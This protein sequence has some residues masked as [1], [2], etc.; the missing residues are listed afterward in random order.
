MPPSLSK[1]FRALRKIL[2]LSAYLFLVYMLVVA[3]VVVVSGD[4]DFDADLHDYVVSDITALNPV[5]VA[6]IIAPTTTAE[7]VAAITDS[8]GPISIGGGRYSMGGQTAIDRGLQIDMRDYDEVVAFSAEDREVTVQAG[9]SWRELQDFIDPYDL[10]VKIMQTYANFSIG[11]SVSVN[12]H[13][14]YIGHGPV[15]SSVRALQLVLADGSVVRASRDENSQ[16]FNAAIGGYGGIAVIAEVTLSLAVN[17]KVE[18]STQTMPIADYREHFVANVRDNEDIV[19]HNADI[20]PPDFTAVRD[21][22]WHTSDK[23]LTIEDRLIATDD[24]YFL[25][26]KMVSFSNSGG[27]GKWTRRAVI[28]PLYYSSDRVAW[29]NWEASYDV[30]ELGEGDR[31]DKTWVLQE[32][33]IPVENFD[34]FVPKMRDIFAAYDVDV[35]NVSIRHALPDPDSY[36]SWARTEVFAFVVYHSQGTTDEDERKVGYWTRA[37]VDAIIEHDGAYYLPY[38][39]HATA[40]QFLAAYPGAGSYFAVKQ[41]VDPDNRFQ[42]K[43]WEKYYPTKRA[44]IR[45]Y[46]D[47]LPDYKKGEEQTLLSLPEWYLV[48]NPNEYADFLRSGNN[49]SDFPFM[50]SIDEYWSLYDRVT[51]LTDDLYPKNSEYQIM[52]WVIGVSTTAEYVAKSAYENTIGRLTRWAA[53]S[54][55]AEDLLLQEAHS[56]YGEL[57]NYEPWYKFPFW[58]YVGRAWGDTPFFGENFIRKT[59]RKMLITAEFGFKALYAK[60]IAYGAESAYGPSSGGVTMH[61]IA[62]AAAI[63]TFDPRIEVVKDF[64]DGDVIVQMPRWGEFSEL[65]PLLADAD[66]RFVEISGNDE[67]VMSTLAEASSSSQPSGSRLLFT[68]PV[69]S[70]P[71]RERS[72]YLVPVEDLDHALRSLQPSGIELE[73]LFD[74]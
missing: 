64:G 49:P 40:E 20:Y 6:S 14:R 54:D 47:G 45:E 52:L 65:M 55:T 61:V 7:I 48:F 36:L 63:E 70:P 26:P 9:M 74:F 32:Y 72:V 53:S 73:H 43:L 27:F 31:S 67:I 33:F 34:A 3:I 1:F 44:R 25:L 29:R 69:V 41:Q 35:V 62:D 57:I 13:G 28:D 21:V 39:P 37:M 38:Q 68:S 24:S 59:E 66:V 18:R 71:G 12:V 19:F 11:G 46:L 17:S 30:R 42:N 51:R 4:D 2:R 15:I 56:A 22:S 58:S 60:A 8:S 23:D 10:S 16:L 5:P 50:A